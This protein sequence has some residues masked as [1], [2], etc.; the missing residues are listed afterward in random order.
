MSDMRPANW[1]PGATPYG[2]LALEGAVPGA[3]SIPDGIVPASGSLAEYLPQHPDGRCVVQTAK[4][5]PCPS[6]PAHGTTA[7]VGHLN[8][9]ARYEREIAAS[10]PPTE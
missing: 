7:C 6:P 10:N 5:L 4:G 2:S 3:T 8:S 9:I 1:A